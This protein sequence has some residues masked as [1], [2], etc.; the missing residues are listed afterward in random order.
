MIG[1]SAP[2][3][4][5]LLFKSG[6]GTFTKRTPVFSS[7]SDI[8]EG[9][10]AILLYFFLGPT[11]L[12]RPTWSTKVKGKSLYSSPPLIGTPTGVKC[13]PTINIPSY[14]SPPSYLYGFLRISPLLNFSNGLPNLKSVY[15]FPS[16]FLEGV[17]W[18]PLLP[19]IS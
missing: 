9:N 18:T 8:L 12:N 16:G 5:V 2:Q 17:K 1:K 10:C 3:R 11:S 14:S 4:F 19:P 13:G 15:I 6:I 7:P